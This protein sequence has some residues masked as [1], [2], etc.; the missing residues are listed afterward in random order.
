MRPFPR[1]HLAAAIGVALVTACSDPALDVEPAA[2]DGSCTRLGAPLVEHACFHAQFG[3]F[4]T[5]AGSATR[6]FP[7]TT[8]NVNTVHTHYTVTLP[9]AAG[10]N[11]GTVKY[12]PARTGDFA[13][14]TASSAGLLVLDAAGA[15]VPTQLRHAVPGD[16]C[17][18]LVEAHVVSLVAAQTYRFVIGPAAGTSVGLVIEKLSDFEGFFFADAD[19]DGFGNP[20]TAVA[21]ACVAPAGHVVDDTDCDDGLA[22]VFPGAAEL[23]DG[24]DNDCDGAVDEDVVMATFYR[25]GDGDGA[26]DPAATATGCAA[27]AGYVLAA[28]DCDD[29]D[30]A[31]HPAASEACDGLDNDCDGAVD[32]GVAPAM[33]Y[34]DRDGDG[35]GDPAAGVAACSPPAGHVGTAGDCDDGLATVFPGA[36]ELCDGLDNDCDGAVDE[37][38]GAATFYRDGDGDGFGDPGQVVTACVAPAGYVTAEGDCD[39][40]NPEVFP[41]EHEVC[42]GLDNDCDGAADNLP[43]ELGEVIEHGCLHGQFGPFATVSAAA[44]GGAAP[45]VSAEHMA[46]NVDLIAGDGGFV[47]DVELAADETGDLVI[48]TGPGVPVTVLD[49][50]GDPVAIED[51]RGVDCA[52]LTRAHVVE[53][54]AGATYRL[55]LGPT[56]A[57]QALLVIERA[58]HDHEGE[59]GEDHEHETG[60]LAFFRDGDGDGFGDPA[61]SV[62]ACAAPAGY[63]ADG[64]DCDDAQA[65]VHPDAAEVCDGADNDCDGAVDVIGGEDVC[66]CADVT[67]EARRSY[68]PPSGVDG[69]LVL[70]GTSALVVPATLPVVRGSAGRGGAVLTFHDAATGAAVAC[71]Y[72]GERRRS[73]AVAGAEPLPYTL[74][75][76]DGGATA[77]AAVRADRV[78]LR[79]DGGDP[80]QGATIARVELDVAACGP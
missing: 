43:D 3:P 73:F 77:G 45:D 76:C 46:F 62:E 9:G 57:A 6:S 14:L 29:G 54:E 23:C 5:V 34:P 80:W 49:P 16:E 50:A 68:C 67:L 19:G 40:G 12:R 20:E 1:A 78:V 79:L 58:G 51:E 18:V 64:S 55:R 63:V 26:G 2:L 65:S 59:E 36:A 41:G 32:D 24:L 8:P 33:Y 35:A 47:G 75:S 17:G 56:A 39:D 69:D 13:I 22:T 48:M 28:G 61:L 25:D 31:R 21:T 53:A 52:V 60:A 4:V 11:E 37:D 10:A 66:A 27:P 42:D 72:R 74:A 30:P 70:A 38:G 44:P 15:A 7:A 71:R